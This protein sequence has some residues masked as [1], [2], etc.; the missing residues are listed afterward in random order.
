MW[1]YYNFP[2][3]FPNNLSANYNTYP[4][5]WIDNVGWFLAAANDTRFLLYSRSRNNISNTCSFFAHYYKSFNG[6]KSV[7]IFINLLLRLIHQIQILKNN[8]FLRSL[9]CWMLSLKVYFHG[10]CF[11]HDSCIFNADG[12]SML[13]NDGR[14]YSVGKKKRNSYLPIIKS[15]I[16]LSI[17]EIILKTS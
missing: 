11:I 4:I 8:K 9:W 16:K 3:Y 7:L 10:I 17:E 2:L 5:Y 1:T 6:E 14:N 15:W 12:F 13:C